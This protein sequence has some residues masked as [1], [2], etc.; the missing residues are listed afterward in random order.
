MERTSHYDYLVVS[1]WVC[2]ARTAKVKPKAVAAAVAAAEATT[3]TTSTRTDT[4]GAV[5]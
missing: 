5:Y 2:L 4:K 3:T 1:A